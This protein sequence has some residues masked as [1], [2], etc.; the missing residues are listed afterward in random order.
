MNGKESYSRPHKI[1][2]IEIQEEKLLQMESCCFS[3]IWAKTELTIILQ[4]WRFIL[5]GTWNKKDLQFF[6]IFF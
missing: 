5:E 3:E 6:I 2:A 1:L 4:H